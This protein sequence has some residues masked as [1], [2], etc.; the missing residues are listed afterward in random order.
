M[1]KGNKQRKREDLAKQVIPNLGEE[2]RA[3]HD[4]G[5]GKASRMPKLAE[6]IGPTPGTT[7]QSASKFTKAMA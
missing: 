7:T 4:L 3:M 6:A 1:Q 2:K 5:H